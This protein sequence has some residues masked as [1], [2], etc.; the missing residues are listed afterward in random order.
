MSDIVGL[1]RFLTIDVC[2]QGDIK[3]MLKFEFACLIILLDNYR[4]YIEKKEF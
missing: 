1:N 4:L 3:S 2:L